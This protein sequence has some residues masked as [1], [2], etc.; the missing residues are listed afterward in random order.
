MKPKTGTLPEIMVAT[1]DSGLCKV[2]GAL[3][4]SDLMHFLLGVDC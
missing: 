1:N 3:W 2:F 4:L